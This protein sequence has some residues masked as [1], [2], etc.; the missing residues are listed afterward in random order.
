MVILQINDLT[1]KRFY[2]Y[3]ETMSNLKQLISKIIEGT[4]FR[5]AAEKTGINYSKLFRLSK[6]PELLEDNIETLENVR[7]SLKISK[8]RFW[9]NLTDKI[10]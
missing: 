6:N 8:S 4:S 5:K 9:A 10:E 1:L 3:N 7:Q 2:V